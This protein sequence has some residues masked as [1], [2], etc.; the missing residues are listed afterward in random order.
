MTRP[1]GSNPEGKPITFPF[2]SR[3]GDG[4]MTFRPLHD[5][6]LVKRREVTED[7]HGGSSF[8][9]RP[10]TNRTKVKGSRLVLENGGTMVSASP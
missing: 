8:P 6:V 2:L 5:R 9:I 10:K 3:E 4:D 7:Q 1:R